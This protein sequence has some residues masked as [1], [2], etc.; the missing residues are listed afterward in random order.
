[1]HD[2]D[3]LADE[4]TAPAEG[5]PVY[6]DMED[7]KARLRFCPE[8]GRI[9]LDDRRMTLIHVSALTALR[10]E[11]VDSL[12]MEKARGLLTRMFYSSGA[13]D[14]ELARRLR[15]GRSLQ[16]GYAVGPQ[17]HMLEG[18]VRVEPV[19][20]E[21]D[22]SRGHFYGEFLWLDSAEAFAHVSTFGVGSNPVCWMQ[23][24]Y[25]AGFTTAFVGRP[26]HYREVE[27]IGAGDARCRIVGRPVEEWGDSVEDL[28]FF[29][30]EAFAGRV[31]AAQELRAANPRAGFAFDPPAAPP[32]FAEGLVGAS[33]A[34]NAACHLVGKV[35][36]SRATV[37]FLGETGVG[38][39]MFARTLHRVSKR[40]NGPFVA[41]NCAA[42]PEGLIESELFGIERGAFTGATSSRPGRFERADGGTLFLDEVGSLSLAAQGKLLRALQS[43]EIERVGDVRTRTTDVRVVAATNE[44]LQQKVAAGAFRAD[45]YYRLKVFPIRVPPLRQRRDDVPILTRYFL[46]KFCAIYE[47]QIAGLTEDAIGA[48]LD[49][50]YP[51]NVRELEHMIERAVILA[52]DGDPLDVAMLFESDAPR[53]QGLAVRRGGA[54]EPLGG[55]EKQTSPVGLESL[56]E[57][58]LRR[59]VSLNAVSEAMMRKALESA[60]GNLTRAARAI[61]LTRPQLAYRL[62]KND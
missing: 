2:R 44:D 38:K 56:V 36:S 32:T 40:A 8:E 58:A 60:G 17:L 10:R 59:N 61:G 13:S 19:R 48:L 47:K 26:I 41:V 45:L 7:L 25:A 21:L 39:E 9:W 15:S 31:A 33:S 57:E 3:P 43:G 30:P 52:S 53:T 5:A 35:G 46:T 62:Q 6:P 37:L 42:I 28:R 14:A 55:A 12:G 18:M 27:C 20:I 11:M 4:V 54:L 34:F 23:I 51:G 49:Y 22:P 29:H 24:G 1:M 16:D 50:E